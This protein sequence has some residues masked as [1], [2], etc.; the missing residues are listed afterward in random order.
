MARLAYRLSLAPP[1][2][3][4]RRV[5]LTFMDSDVVIEGRAAAVLAALVVALWVK[6]LIVSG[7]QVGARVRGRAFARTEDAAMMGRTP[8]AEPALAARAADAWRNETENGPVFL[9]IAAVAVLTGVSWSPLA[10]AGMAFLLARFVH[11]WAQFAALQPLR[12]IAWLAGLAAT[13]ALSGATLAAA[14][15]LRP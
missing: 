6:G 8:Q 7:V 1:L 10:L 4:L 13:T 11:A 14:W 15:T 9:A 5:S 12:T 3:R 2:S